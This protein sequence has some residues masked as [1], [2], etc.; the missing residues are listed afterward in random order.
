[1]TR[2]TSRGWTR[3]APLPALW[4]KTSYLVT[5]SDPTLGA[6]NGEDGLPDLAI[7]RL[8]ATT[9]EEAEALVQKVLEWEDTAQS[10]GG[11]AILVADNPGH[12]RLGEA[13]LAAQA[14]Y[15]Q[16]GVMPE[17]LAIY[18]LFGD[19]GMLIR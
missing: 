8:P 6:V 1:M 2:G 15:A 3:G 16:T 11:K 7:G 10:L 13:V 4:A 17:L 19:P 18:H 14:A 12:C 5:S 9:V